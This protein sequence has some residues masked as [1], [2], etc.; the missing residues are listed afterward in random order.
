M[1]ETLVLDEIVTQPLTMVRPGCAE[2]RSDHTPRFGGALAVGSKD[3]RP[4][5][6]TNASGP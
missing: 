3:R 1:F 5:C 4:L 2:R 6:L